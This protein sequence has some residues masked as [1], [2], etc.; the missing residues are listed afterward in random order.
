MRVFAELI[1]DRHAELLRR[2]PSLAPL[3][4]RAYL[5][6][7]LGVREL[8]HEALEEQPA[9]PLPALS[10]DIAAWI[11]ATFEGA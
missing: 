3:P 4:A 7:V 5:G 9:L 8:V 2:K 10:P 6:L 1:A 11:T